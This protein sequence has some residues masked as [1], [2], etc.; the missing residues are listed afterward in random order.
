[1]QLYLGNFSIRIRF[2]RR[3]YYRCGYAIDSHIAGI[4]PTLAVP[5]RS[6]ITVSLEWLKRVLKPQAQW[7]ANHLSQ[8]R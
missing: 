1:M 5:P 4:K 6:T 3:K 8:Q 2:S 7:Q